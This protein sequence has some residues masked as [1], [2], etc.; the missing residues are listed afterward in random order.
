MMKKTKKMMATM[1]V[2]GLVFAVPMK[3]EA[4]EFGLDTV[5][6]DATSDLVFT[7]DTV[8][9]TVDTTPTQTPDT[10]VS[11]NDNQG[12]STGNVGNGSESTPSI[13]DSTPTVPDK[14]E[15]STQAAG[16]TGST[17]S[18]TT[19]NYY[20]STTYVVPSNTST[21]SASSATTGTTAGTSASVEIPDATVNATSSDDGV[22]ASIK[23]NWVYSLNEKQRKIVLKKYIGTGKVVSVPNTIKVNGKQL[24]VVIG[25]RT[26][27]GNKSITKVTMGKNVGCQSTNG[28]LSKLFY[29]CKSL[30]TVTNLPWD[31]RN[32]TRTFYGCSKLAKVTGIPDSVSR[33]SYCFAGCKSLKAVTIPDDLHPKCGYRMLKGTNGIKL[34]G[35]SRKK[36]DTVVG[37]YEG[38]KNVKFAN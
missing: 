37:F 36:A 31:A 11:S 22:S 28:N 26:F 4:T 30:K 15:N 21:G 33:M 32:L 19:N 3:A 38:A 17:G 18:T 1:L 2:L 34:S 10:P 9:E 24:N 5:Y 16:N 14:S 25:P 13:P 7:T 27:Y 20:S 6:E 23:K 29:G 8:T 12:S 35:I